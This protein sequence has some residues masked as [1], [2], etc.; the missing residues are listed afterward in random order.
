[1]SFLQRSHLTAGIYVFVLFFNE[2]LLMFFL[3]HERKMS[4]KD[5]VTSH[6]TRSILISFLGLSGLS[7][8]FLI[9]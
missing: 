9:S 6:F 7:N 8:P 5:E 2:L 3:N 4:T 1:M